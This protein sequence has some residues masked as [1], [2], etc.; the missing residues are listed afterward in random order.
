DGG[1]TWTPVEAQGIGA[2]RGICGI[3]VAPGGRLIHAAGRVGG[4]AAIMRSAD[5]GETWRVRD[6]SAAAGMILDVKFLDPRHGFLCA[7]TSSDLEQANALILRTSD[8]GATWA[9]VYRSARRFENCWKMHFP[10]RRTGYATVQNY[11]PG[12]SRR[13]IVK[14]EDGGASWRELPL[15][16]DARVREFG[17]GFVDENWGWA[18][19]STSGFETRDGGLSWTPVDMGRAVNKIRIVRHGRRTRAFAIGT[20]VLRRDIA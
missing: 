12:T 7:A 9:P 13:V 8:G 19:T 14:T 1:A 11:E 20:N 15:V 16:D 17:I 18:G 5:G 4:P 6:L 3:D 10:S 2:V